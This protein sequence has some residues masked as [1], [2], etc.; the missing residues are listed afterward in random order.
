MNTFNPRLDILSSAQK[1]LWAALHFTRDLG[2]VLYG[3]TAIALRLGHRKSVDFDFFSDRSIDKSIIYKK[4]CFSRE[5]IVLQD[6]PQ[7]LTLLISSGKPDENDVK[8]SFFGKIGIGRVDDPELTDDRVLQVA[9]L[10]D[11]MATK[12]KVIL[13]RVESKD[14][15]DMAALVDAGVSL[16][17][18]LA[19]A[20]K[21]YEG[22]FQP[23]ESLKAMTYFKGGDLELLSEKEKKILI[24]AAAKVRDLPEVEIVSRCLAFNASD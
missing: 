14:Y 7:A 1:R 6:Q 17:R 12:L 9:S 16:P 19:A 3:G 21:M 20:R 5:A 23:M 18:A 10:H 4:F 2:F 11:L 15:R 22:R 13:Q 8:V 24:E